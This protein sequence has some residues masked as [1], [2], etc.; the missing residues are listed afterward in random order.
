L[1]HT[2]ASG[3]QGA[4]R[5]GGGLSSAGSAPARLDAVAG[6]SLM[7]YRSRSFSAA[8]C[9]RYRWRW[10]ECMRSLRVAGGS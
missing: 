1:L 2:R 10:I 6:A 3:Q 5:E 8:T 4:G 7:T 9:S